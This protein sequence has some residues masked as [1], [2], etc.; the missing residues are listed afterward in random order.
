M[1][2]ERSEYLR[3]VE[4]IRRHDYAYYVQAEPTITDRQYDALYRKLLD[5]EQAHPDW[6]VDDSPTR[7]VGG[8][9]LEGFESV[10]HEVPMLSLDNT[11]SREEVIAFIKKVKR[12]LPDSEPLFTVEPKVDGVAVSVRYEDGH[13]VR[14]TTRGDGTMGDD[15]TQNLRTLRSIPL[16][17]H[18]NPGPVLEVRGEVFMTRKGFIHMNEKRVKAGDAPFA[19]A[20]NATAGSLKQ[21]DSRLVSERPLDVIFYGFGAMDIN[22]QP[23]T[24]VRFMELLREC[25]LPAPEH[26]WVCDSV[27]AIADALSELDQLRKTMPYET[28]GAVVKLDSMALREEIGYTSKAPRWAMAYKFEAEQGITRLHAITVQVGRTG[29]LTPVAELEPIPL[30]G[31]TVSRATLHNEDDMRRKDVRIGDL[32]IIEK[33]GEV[34]PAVVRVETSERTGKEKEFSFPGEC[35]ECRTT[36]VRETHEIS[37]NTVHRCPNRECPAQVRGR[38]IHWCSRGGMDIEGGGEVLSRQLVESG[39]V[40][41]PADL[42]RLTQDQ[43]A[44]LERMGSRSARNF[45]DGV[46][47]SKSR[48]LWR[49]IFSLGIPHVGTSTAKRLAREFYSIDAI[50]SASAE[51]LEA[52]EDIGGIMAAAINSWFEDPPN[53]E[54]IEELRDLG[55][56][57]AD[58]V[59][60]AGEQGERILEGMSI[61][62]T[63]TLPNLKRKQAADLIEKHGGKAASSV[64]SKTAFVVAGDEAGSKLEKANKLGIP[65]LSEEEFLNKIGESI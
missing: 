6:I 54:L 3:L 17:L 10:R 38:L 65:V 47:A 59:P 61:V 9:P 42:Y 40:R 29:L 41:T 18:R 50:A 44:G 2:D 14:A 58:P 20:R 39:L 28:D 27:E 11:Y 45:L 63:G 52:V 60:E 24:N 4:E 5:F 1:A 64:S 16:R 34:I 7:K 51:Q 22:E 31:S 55:L 53:R 25:G 21:L 36:T 12:L 32:V 62:L 35:P 8:E 19:N 46:E 43:V 49:L 48:D 23:E 26:F 37:G 56:R 33:A 13:F 15:I 57:L 30:A